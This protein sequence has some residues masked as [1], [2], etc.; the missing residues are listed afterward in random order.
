MKNSVFVVFCLML[1]M[2]FSLTYAFMRSR[3]NGADEMQMQVAILQDKVEREEL[4]SQL[5]ANQLQEYQ[6]QIAT[7]IPE[8]QKNSKDEKSAYQLRVLASVVA[9][10]D[11][12]RLKIERATGMFE[13]AKEEFRIGKFEKAEA[14]FK[15]LIHRY[16]ES[17]H[18][19]EAHF[20]LAET[21]FQLKEYEVCIDTVEAMVTLFP[22]SE[23]TGFAM[24][25]LAKIYEVQDR[26][27]DAV[28]LYRTVVSSYQDRQLVLQ[29]NTSLKSVEL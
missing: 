20:L 17:I 11:G 3:F 8:A 25:R 12:D 7:M 13:R 2:T 27:E 23:L 16:P 5:A 1:A 14:D 24:L 9:T 28:E 26:L 22:E 15:D 6:Q 4:K 21:Q 19:P 10:P 29:A 18:V